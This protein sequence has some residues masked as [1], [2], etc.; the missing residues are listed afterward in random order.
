M[1]QRYYL[2]NSQ[3]S[4][5]TMPT[6]GSS[7]MHATNWLGTAMLCLLLSSPLFAA[8]PEA[9]PP[10]PVD[11]VS[12]AVYPPQ[13]TLN[14]GVDFQS[15]AAVS[16]GGDGVTEDVTETARW[17]VIDPEIAKI[18]GQRLLPLAD[19][20]TQLVAN[21]NGVITR[22][23]V[24]VDQAELVPDIS[25][26]KD[27]M[28]VFTRS[29]CNTGSCHG[30]ARGKDGFRLSLFGFDPAGDYHRITREF[31]FRRINLAVPSESLL[32]KKAVGD[33]PHTGGRLFDDKSDYYE[34]IHRWLQAGAPADSP[35][36][37]PPAVQSIAVYPPQMVIQG[38]GNR[39]RLVAVA[40][41]ADGSTRDLSR[42]AT[43]SSNNSSVAAVSE[44]GA[45]TAG[46]SVKGATRCALPA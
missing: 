35:D 41:Y 33:V 20:Q 6:T 3:R 12:L 7:L 30:A 24:T 17:R 23:D 44:E 37:M 29:G 22:V 31:G 8:A 9:S 25:F 45:I 46:S 1:T 28:P 16:T 15:F 14:S 34:T 19:G 18:D 36:A 4:R 42:L 26:A 11:T 21:L 2:A 5:F 43:F 32:L 13:I 38:E 27:V 10:Q 39:Q 40:H